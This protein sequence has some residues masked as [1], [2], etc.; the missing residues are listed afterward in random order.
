VLRARTAKTA[1]VRALADA[2][3]GGDTGDDALVV[4]EGLV[5]RE[6]LRAVGVGLGDARLAVQEV[7]LLEGET[8]GLGVA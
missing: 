1:V 6:H 2:E 8:L 4:R 7:D 5:L 3:L